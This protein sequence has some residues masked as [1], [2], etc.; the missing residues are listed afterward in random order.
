MCHITGGGLG[1]N[2]RRVV[3]S[4]LN[5]KYNNVK[6]KK[7][8]QTGVKVIEDVSETPKKKCIAFF[9]CGVGFVIIV[10]QDKA[11]T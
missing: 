1:E 8:I 3:P 5:I 10:S 7:C 2:L 9:N 6:L 4:K 11:K